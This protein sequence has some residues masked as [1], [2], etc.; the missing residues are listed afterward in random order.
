MR[1]LD[2]I[3]G[4]LG[5]YYYYYCRYNGNKSQIHTLNK[6]GVELGILRGGGDTF[7]KWLAASATQARMVWG[8]PP[9]KNWNLHSQLI[10][11]MT[12]QAETTQKVAFLFTVFSSCLRSPD[13]PC[14]TLHACQIDAHWMSRVQYYALLNV[15][16][17]LQL[18]LCRFPKVSVVSVT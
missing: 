2:N 18:C 5:D 6:A 9:Q 16:V 11:F 15:V 3:Y 4:L 10:H 8:M 13:P 12:F 7:W 1:Y 17:Q 14:P